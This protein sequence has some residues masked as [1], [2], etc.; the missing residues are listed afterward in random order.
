MR[1]LAISEYVTLPRSRGAIARVARNELNFLRTD[2]EGTRIAADVIA[3]G[4]LVVYP[5]DTTYAIGANALDHDAVQAVR[6]LKGRSATKAMSIIIAESEEIARYSSVDERQ[7]NWA[8][9]L[10]P[11][12]VTLVFNSSVSGPTLACS[13][14]TVGIRIPNSGFC[15]NLAMLAGVPITATS[16]NLSGEKEPYEL[17]DAVSRLGAHAINV[18]LFID[19]GALTSQQ[20]STVIDLTGREPRILRNGALPANEVRRL[21]ADSRPV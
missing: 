15:R 9:A 19:G 18:Q 17:E 11:G 4:G 21:T 16:A 2:I 3:S 13:D 5:T 8:R 12:P 20:P 1:R 10:L 7:M 14:S 6:R